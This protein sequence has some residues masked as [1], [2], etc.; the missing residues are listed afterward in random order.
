MMGVIKYHSDRSRFNLVSIVFFSGFWIYSSDSASLFVSYS[1]LL[2]HFIP[3]SATTLSL[4]PWA[5]SWQE[6][7]ADA[8]S[9]F[10]SATLYHFIQ[11]VSHI[12]CKNSEKIAT[13]RKRQHFFMRLYVALQIT[14]TKFRAPYVHSSCNSSTNKILPRRAWDIQSNQHAFYMKYIFLC[15]FWFFQFKFYHWYSLWIILW[16][17]LGISR[18]FLAYFDLLC[19]RKMISVKKCKS[20][21]AG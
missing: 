21:V 5:A 4:P 16:L 20:P 18:L 15:F 9:V 3:N 8:L 13:K 7:L 11:Y 2:R 6:A 12:L 10:L 1:H 17:F 19:H 14:E